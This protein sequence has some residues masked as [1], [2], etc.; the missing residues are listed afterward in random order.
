VHEKLQK[1]PFTTSNALVAQTGLTAPTI[2][3]ALE[4]L[5]RLDIVQEV[6]GRRRGR[7]FAYRSY[8]DILDEGTA[9]ITVGG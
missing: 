9:P 5:Q 6:T 2:N 1:T 8:L 7:V 4:D 3:A